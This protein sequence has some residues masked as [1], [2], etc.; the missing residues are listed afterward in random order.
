MQRITRSASGFVL[1]IVL[2]FSNISTAQPT[3]DSVYPGE[4]PPASPDDRNQPGG[5]MADFRVN[6]VTDYIFRGIKPFA[7]PQSDDNKDGLALQFDGKVSIDLGKLPHPYISVFVNVGDNDPVSSFQEVR[8]TVG[9]DWPLKPIILSAGH[10]SYI[11][12]NRSGLDTG[13][14]F[15]RIELDDSD[16][17]GR[18]RPLLRPYV[19]AAYDYDLYDGLY[20]QAGLQP[21]IDVENTGLS[22][23]LD[24]HAAYVAQHSFFSQGLLEGEAGFE[25]T[26]FQHWQVGLIGQYDLNQALNIPE[27]FGQWSVLGYLYYTSTFDDALRGEDL[28]WGGGGFKLA[29]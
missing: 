26:G 1:G 7:D 5:V 10:T 3:P 4:L 12:P 16:I 19:F 17:F 25:D 29:F 13:E 15:V 20:L 11:Y 21:K 8:P 2:G 14:I 22:F 9:F 23:T 27:R 6:Y 28:L 24:A 18:E